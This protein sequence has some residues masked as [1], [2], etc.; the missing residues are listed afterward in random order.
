MITSSLNLYFF[1]SWIK[2]SYFQASRPANTSFILL[3][4]LF[5][6]MEKAFSRFTRFFRGWI[7]PIYK[8]YSLPLLYLF[9]VASA[10]SP[11]TGLK[12]SFAALYTTFIFSGFIL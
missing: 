6:K 5:L 1:K 4:C 9:F 10:V 11:F 3:F 8:K 12:I 7:A 2:E